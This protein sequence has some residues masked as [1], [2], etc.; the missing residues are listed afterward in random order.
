MLDQETFYNDVGDPSISSCLSSAVGAMP[1]DV[2][3]VEVR[4]RG[5]HMGTFEMLE[6]MHCAEDVAA[7]IAAVHGVHSHDN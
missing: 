5:L 1:D 3:L 7:K 2:R 4:Y 6:L